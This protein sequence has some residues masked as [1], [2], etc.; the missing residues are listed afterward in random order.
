MSLKDDVNFS[1]SPACAIFGIVEAASLKFAD[2]LSKR[3][4]SLSIFGLASLGKEYVPAGNCLGIN[5]LSSM[6]FSLI[7]D[8]AVIGILPLFT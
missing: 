8:E 7:F 5:L 2:I 1:K 6:I 3:A 4:R